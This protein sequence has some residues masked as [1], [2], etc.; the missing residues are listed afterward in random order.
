MLARAAQV[1]IE[2]QGVVDADTGVRLELGAR[3]HRVVLQRQGRWQLLD[4]GQLAVQPAAQAL[5]AHGVLERGGRQQLQ[6]DVVGEHVGE[7]QAQLGVAVQGRLGARYL[8][9]IEFQ[10]ATA[11]VRRSGD[12][13]GADDDIARLVGVGNRG[14]ERQ[15]REGGTEQGLVHGSSQRT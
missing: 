1:F 15:G 3:L 12:G 11:F 5:D 14:G 9:A 8:V 4:V 7:G 6:A 10:V 2:E 13:A